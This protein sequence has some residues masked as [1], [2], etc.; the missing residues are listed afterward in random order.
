M[1]TRV[2]VTGAGGSL[3]SEL[4]RQFSLRDEYKAIAMTSEKQK[5]ISLSRN[6]NCEIFCNSELNKL[7]NDPPDVIIHCAFA[8]NQESRQLVTSL[9]FMDELLEF[10]TNNQVGS[11]VYIS[12]KSVYGQNQEPRWTEDTPVQPLSMYSMAKYSG[13]LLTGSAFYMP[14]RVF[15]TNLRLSNITGPGCYD[16]L[17]SK[18]VQQAINKQTITIKGGSQQFSFLDKRDAADAIVA[19]IDKGGNKWYRTFNLGPEKIYSLTEIVN[20]VSEVS[21]RF[22]NEPLKI[23]Y[24]PLDAPLY[25]GLDSSL[26]FNSIGWVP[27]YS[28]AD[29]IEDVFM[30]YMKI[31]H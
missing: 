30:D 29:T 12:S 22:L 27:K 14:S 6:S 5:L 31:M 23:V 24:A 15:F 9:N 13:E 17:L 2:L 11:F 21:L 19:L 3:G 7:E 18:L 8:R 20:L 10:A 25:D 1:I 28:M 4:I 26:F 16:K